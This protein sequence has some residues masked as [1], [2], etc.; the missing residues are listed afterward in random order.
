M[1]RGVESGAEAA[2]SSGRANGTN[3]LNVAQHTARAVKIARVILFYLAASQTRKHRG[4]LALLKLLGSAARYEDPRGRR[5]IHIFLLGAD[6]NAAHLAIL[7]FAARRFKLEP[8]LIIE[9][10]VQLVEEWSE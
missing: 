10:D 7:L 5:E 1:I 3:Q 6:A 4:R 2:R 8:V 9:H